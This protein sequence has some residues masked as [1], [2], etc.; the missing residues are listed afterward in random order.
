MMRGDPSGVFC[1]DWLLIAPGNEDL[2]KGFMKRVTLTAS[3]VG[4]SRGLCSSRQSYAS[5]SNLHSKNG[6]SDKE[7][8]PSIRKSRSVA[9][10]SHGHVPTPASSI[11][12][13]SGGF[14]ISSGTSSMRHH[15]SSQKTSKGSSLMAE[16]EKAITSE[17]HKME[18][19]VLKRELEKERAARV[20]A[21]SQL[22]LL[23]S[24]TA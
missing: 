23:K 12:R 24:V 5:A 16:A 13:S 1:P 19:E 15:G 14:S 10:V 7:S 22:T 3:S 6:M 17:F 18:L 9:D 4:S 8:P 21:E 20:R 2:R 11:L